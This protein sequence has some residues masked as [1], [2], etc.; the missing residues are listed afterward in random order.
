[1]PQSV[2]LSAQRASNK[3]GNLVVSQ[4]KVLQSA[5]HPSLLCTIWSNVLREPQTALMMV[6]GTIYSRD[7]LNPLFCVGLNTECSLK[8]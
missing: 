2:S 5:M 3:E 1:M 7:T 4:I 8:F 6:G